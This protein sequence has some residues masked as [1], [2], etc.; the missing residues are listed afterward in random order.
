MEER[1]DRGREQLAAVRVLLA[2]VARPGGQGTGGLVG[3]MHATAVQEVHG[4]VVALEQPGPLRDLESF[5]LAVGPVPT[6]ARAQL[7]DRGSLGRVEH[8][9]DRDDDGIGAHGPI[10]GAGA[11]A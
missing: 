3:P 2:E 7:L 4:G 11:D 9:V 6:E 10:V 5:A 1:L 8:G